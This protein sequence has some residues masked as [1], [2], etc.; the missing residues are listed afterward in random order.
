MKDLNNILQ[1]LLLPAQN[2]CE[3]PKRLE[4]CQKAL[5]LVNKTQ[6]SEL[7]AALQ[8]EMGN[9]L[10]KNPWGNRA[11]NLEKATHHYQNALEVYNPDFFPNEHRQ[12]QKNIGNLHF[13]QRN[14]VCAFKAFQ[15]A[16]T[17]GNEI[18]VAGYSEAG[19]EAEMSEIAQ[20]FANASYCLIQSQQFGEALVLLESAKTRLISEAMALKDLDLLTLPKQ[21]RSEMHTVRQAVKHLEYEIGQRNGRS[22]YFGPKRLS[23]VAKL[24]EK[25]AELKKIVKIIREEF[26]GF[27]ST[28]LDLP[29]ILA[30]IP[31]AG[32]LLAPVV[33]K[34]GSATFI[35]P[36][37]TKEITTK[38][39][40]ILDDF[41]GN[42]FYAL[43][44]CTKLWSNGLYGKIR[45]GSENF[46]L[47]SKN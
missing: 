3:I 7:W 31:P 14:W 24:R 29:S 37:D 15:N 17:A 13:E 1:K 28:C 22:V 33:T 12:T 41:K 19:R 44:S 35:I 23:L 16:I 38:N 45:E 5:R 46:L 4:L 39:V 9:N 30:A 40:V 47:L 2:L 21:Y 34:Q 42:D 27:I 11:D 43:L 26:P 32:S 25:R 10:V 8:S 20:I 18:F 36:H 6:Q